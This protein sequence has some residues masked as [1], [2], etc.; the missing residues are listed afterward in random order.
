MV[1]WMLS[2]VA[3]RMEL[4][5]LV[6]ADTLLLVYAMTLNVLFYA[7]ATVIHLLLAMLIVIVQP[8][9]KKFAI[10]NTIDTVLI[11]LFAGWG[12]SFG[13]FN[14]SQMMSLKF[15]IISLIGAL[16]TA[17]LPFIYF[18]VVIVHWLYTTVKRLN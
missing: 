6:T 5:A 9:N 8:Y 12:A 3:T 18:L 15:V 4:M 10:Y 14:L 2:K 1:H 11:L 7:L 16:L 13:C 17:I